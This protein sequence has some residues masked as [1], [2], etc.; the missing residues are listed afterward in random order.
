LFLANSALILYF[1]ISGGYKL[2]F[3]SFDDSRFYFLSGVG[4]SVLVLISDILAIP[5]LLRLRF[6]EKG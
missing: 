1:E 3:V 2:N 6:L 5:A 4:Y